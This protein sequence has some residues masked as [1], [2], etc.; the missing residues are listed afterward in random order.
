MHMLGEQLMISPQLLSLLLDMGGQQSLDGVLASVVKGLVDEEDIALARIWLIGPGDICETCLMREE[1][2]DRSRC[3]HLVASAGEPQANPGERWDRLDGEFR[4]FPLGVRK[5]GRIGAGGECLAVLNVA[6]EPDWIVKPD[7]AR[8]EGIQGFAGQ[9]LVFMGEIL[10]VLA[11]FT[12]TPLT[13]HC[14]DWLRTIAD[15]AAAWI[16]NV[17][18]REEIEKLQSRLEHENE[19]LRE[20]VNEA[21]A[22]G[23]IIGSSPALRAIVEQIELVAPTDANVLILGESGTGKELVAQEIHRRSARS[24]RPLI[25]VNCAS[26]P[27]ELYESEF[28]GHVRGAFTG[29]VRDRVGRFGLADGGT[30]FLDEVGEIPYEL[31]SK[32]LRVLQEGTYERIG[33]PRTHKV[34]ARIIAATN[35]D[36]KAEVKESRFRQDLFYRLN[37]FP[38]QVPPLRE[39][40]EDLGALAQEFVDR[41][42][43]RYNRPVL[44]MTTHHILTLG[45]YDW[46]GNV[47]ELMNVIERA[48]ITSRSGE[49]TFDLPRSSR[50]LKDLQPA[51][52]FSMILPHSAFKQMEKE[53]IQMAL[54]QTN[55]QVHGPDGAA[56]LLGMRPTTLASRIKRLGLKRPGGR[57]RGSR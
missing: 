50:E 53:N 33:D 18:A 30:L 36:L 15:L 26:V 5:V 35:R 2:P 1:C 41:A 39:R 24:S 27:R 3:L 45:G 42:S 40:M 31:Q 8:R 22:F 48:V 6:E 38:I 23:S 32:L 16:A 11:I 17:R 44:P 34:D 55:W 49:L 43:R 37:V 10:G 21:L 47:R 56:E 9:P 13:A 20:E 29:A 52:D 14:V 12:R 25:R 19:Y 4:R 28:F 7:W 57:N 51:P 54:E 46:P